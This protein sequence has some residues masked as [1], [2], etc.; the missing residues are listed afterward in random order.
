M[1]KKDEVRSLK[2]K[3]LF[4]TQKKGVAIVKKKRKKY[5]KKKKKKK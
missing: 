1:T 3:E 4:K 2:T 5:G